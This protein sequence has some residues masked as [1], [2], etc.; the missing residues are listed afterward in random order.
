MCVCDVVHFQSINIGILK[1]IKNEQGPFPPR[2]PKEG[3]FKE[4]L[5]LY[6]GH[7]LN[8]GENMH[9]DPNHPAAKRHRPE[10]PP[11]IHETPSQRMYM[12]GGR[13]PPP[14]PAPPYMSG[15]GP[16]PGPGRMG[17]PPPPPPP[18]PG[19][20]GP[21]HRPPPGGAN[22]A[23]S[24][25]SFIDVTVLPVLPRCYRSTTRIPTT[26]ISCSPTLS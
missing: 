17:P 11:P 22:D 4:F 8:N 5:M 10:V 19:Y 20:R 15:L 1:R 21:P 2:P 14:P 25:I 26:W 18:P 24:S 6:K 13:G 3:S 9:S 12:T 23:Y 16:G 7:G